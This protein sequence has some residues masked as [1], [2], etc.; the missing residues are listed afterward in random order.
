ME[1]DNA[2]FPNI[3]GSFDSDEDKADKVA[4]V[5]D[6]VKD[7]AQ[8]DKVAFVTE[9][10]ASTEVTTTEV[11]VLPQTAK[12]EVSNSVSLAAPMTAPP[13]PDHAMMVPYGAKLLLM[14]L[15]LTNI[16]IRSVYGSIRTSRS[17]RH[18]A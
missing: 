7:N 1:L 13:G 5:N 3:T 18:R 9:T 6:A 2:A 8:E 12:G 14:E 17:K 16:L 4:Y 15:H 10:A 11:N